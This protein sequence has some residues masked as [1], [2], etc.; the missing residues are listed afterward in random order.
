M[1]NELSIHI[2]RGGFRLYLFRVAVGDGCDSGFSMIQNCSETGDSK[3]AAL[4]PLVSQV[5]LQEL[6]KETLSGF[7]DLLEQ[8]SP[9]WYP[10]E[11]HE[12]AESVLRLL[13]K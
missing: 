2:S 11:L 8:Y 6:V 7:R 5:E 9:A 12:K 10:R 4:E 3:L 13:E 1:F